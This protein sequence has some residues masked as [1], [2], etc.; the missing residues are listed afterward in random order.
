MICPSPL[1][2]VPH[3]RLERPADGRPA[4]AE[5]IV[6]DVDHHHGRERPPLDPFGE[7]D[8]HVLSLLRA[9]PRFERRRGRAQDQRNAFQLGPL[10]GDFAGVIPRRR[11]LLESR[12]V[13]LVDH[14]QAEM[15]RGSEDRAA[16][17]DHD[18]HAAGGDLL[19]VP[20]PFGIA[21]VAVQD[22]DRFEPFA[23]AADRLRREADLGNEHDRLPSVTH[24]FADR[25]DVD[26][27]LA[28]A[29]DAVQQ[30]GAMPARTLHGEDRVERPLLVAVEGQI[31]LLRGVAGRR[32]ELGLPLADRADQSLLTQGRERR[33]AAVGRLREFGGVHRPARGRQNF[34]HGLLLGR[35]AGGGEILLVPLGT[36][37]RRD[38]PRAG[39]LFNACRHHRLDDLAPTAEVVV[40]DPPRQFEHV[41]RENR[42]AIDD[43]VDGFQAAIGG[44]RR[45]DRHAVTDREPVPFAEG[46]LDPLPRRDERPQ[47]VGDEVIELGIDGPIED[48]ADDHPVGLGGDLPGERLGRQRGGVEQLFLR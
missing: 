47:L 14:D 9:E 45:V 33:C 32:G 10:P 46:R 18:L 22:G 35:E 42:L 15:R 34:E 11:L 12:L 27:G 20:V 4:G 6:A 26:L 13:L 2:H 23:K 40:G 28:A 1:Q 31:G 38:D 21:Q 17:A 5:R 29:G 19:P 25:L 24:H 39:F 41:F 30:D 16:R 37:E 43:R 48:Q 7:R 3:A 44:G 36:H 8:E